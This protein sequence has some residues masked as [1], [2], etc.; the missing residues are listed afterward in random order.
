MYKL[1]K[2]GNPWMEGK[3]CIV[4][5]CKKDGYD[6]KF[7]SFHS[8]EEACAVAGMQKKILVCI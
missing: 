7:Q 4:S 2:L 1:G 6:M 3:R 5:I 8:Q